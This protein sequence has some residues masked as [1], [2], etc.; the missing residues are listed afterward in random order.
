MFCNK[1]LM[2][3]I[4]KRGFL[5]GGPR[6][7]TFT[8]FIYVH[9]A[10][11]I[12]C[13][14]KS[15]WQAASCRNA[16]FSLSLFEWSPCRRHAALNAGKSSPC[17]GP[18]SCKHRRPPVFYVSRYHCIY[19]TDDISIHLSW[20]RCPNPLIEHIPAVESQGTRG[21]LYHHAHSV[22]IMQWEKCHGPSV[23]EHFAEH[24]LVSCVM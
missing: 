21:S 2:N 11:N 23:P 14:C 6:W 10:A 15:I 1:T 4:F 7:R 5:V 18:Q 3:E 16:R 20:C 17:T 24:C 19:S 9:R 8:G 22:W 13:N 12:A